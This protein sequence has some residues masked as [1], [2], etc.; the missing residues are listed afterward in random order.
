V[1]GINGANGSVLWTQTS[2]YQA[3]AA[4]SWLTPYQPTLAGS[5]NS[6][7]LY[8]Q[9]AGGKVFELGNLN[10]SSP[11]PVTTIS[12]PGYSANPTVFNQNVFINTPLTADTSGNVYFGYTVNSS[13]AGTAA[14]NGLTSGIA[15]IDATTHAL[16]FDQVGAAEPQSAPALS[17]DGKQVYFAM[18]NGNLTSF[19]STTLAPVNTVAVPGGFSTTSTASPTVGPDG[20]VYIGNLTPFVFDRGTLY[21]YSA[22]LTQ[23]SAQAANPGG[24]GWDTTTSIVPLSMVPWYHPTD[25]STYLL[26]TKYNGYTSEGGGP[27]YVASLDPNA[28][29]TD[30]LSGR[31][32]MKVVAEVTSP[33]GAEWCINTGVVDPKTD[34]IYVN[35]EDG[36][37]YQWYLGTTGGVLQQ[38]L[39][40]TAGGGQPYTATIVGANGFVYAIEAGQLFAVG[41]IQ[42]VPEPG[43]LVLAAIGCAALAA[44]G[45]RRHVR[46]R[47]A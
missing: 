27:N 46:N 3:Y 14:V 16:T 17:N 9:G 2:D 4:G 41:S 6:A 33:A 15:R 47:T 28:T 39:Q 20:N 29:Q 19:N 21:Q 40:L 38:S 22:N 5:G 42:G 8:Y 37:I 7:D 12:F 44:L 31:Q 43:S 1:Q 11:T 30:L 34:S 35:N 26:F 36:H 18:A 45:W 10:S 25:G 23:T 13:V 32:E 24:F